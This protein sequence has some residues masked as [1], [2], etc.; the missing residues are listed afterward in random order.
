MEEKNDEKDVYLRIQFISGFIL[1]EFE[2][3]I[4]YIR[5]SS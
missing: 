5:K 2:M 4:L 1:P 3:H